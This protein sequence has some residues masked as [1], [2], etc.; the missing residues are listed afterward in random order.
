[1][2]VSGVI[3]K[4]EDKSLPV[5]AAVPSKTLSVYSQLINHFRR[6]KLILQIALEYLESCRVLSKIHCR[7]S[8]FG[9]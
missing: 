8:I 7:T 6:N 4:S 9:L 5:G 3:N 2:A 1:M